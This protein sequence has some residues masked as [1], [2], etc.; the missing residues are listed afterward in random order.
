M[1]RKK[2]VYSSEALL[3]THSRCVLFPP[4]IVNDCNPSAQT[5]AHITLIYISP[6][7]GCEFPEDGDQPKRVAAS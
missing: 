4:C 5:N 1:Y 2:A 3:T 7:L 6:Y